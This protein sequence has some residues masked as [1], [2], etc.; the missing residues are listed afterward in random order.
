M[1]FILVF[2]LIF[3]LTQNG[4]S[5]ADCNEIRIIGDHVHKTKII[6]ENRKKEY[7]L[8]SRETGKLYLHW[9]TDMQT[10]YMISLK[11]NGKKVQTIHKNSIKKEASCYIREK[12]NATDIFTL[13]ISGKERGELEL[14]GRFYSNEQERRIS[15]NNLRLG[16][17]TY[18][19][20][21]YYRFEA[22]RTGIL[23]LTTE[24]QNNQYSGMVAAVSLYDEKKHRYTIGQESLREEMGNVQNYFVKKGKTYYIGVR[25][26]NPYSIKY[27]IR[28]IE[29]TLINKNHVYTLMGKNSPIYIK[30]PKVRYSGYYRFYGNRNLNISI[31][32]EN[33]KELTYQK[34]LSS[35]IVWPMQTG[36]EYY[37]RVVGLGREQVKGNYIRYYNG[38]NTKK[39]R[40]VILKRKKK[41]SGYFSVS[42]LSGKSNWFY[43]KKSKKKRQAVL[44]LWLNG[45]IRIVTYSNSG[46]K[47]DQKNY[48]A[49]SKKINI[50]IP[51][52]GLYIQIEKR[53][54]KSS[55]LYMIF[56]K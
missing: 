45:Q 50:K 19:S 7:Q 42:D 25:D 8:L 21:Q 44:K 54:S 18:G 53:N 4:A 13:E 49:I 34:R 38:K 1:V 55:G 35:S 9:K 43:V 22:E 56:L 27:S 14:E 17:A 41:F 51:K 26:P 20:T 5:R 31:C 36:K 3:F 32:N 24:M 37:V 16:V 2:C 46:K 6:V 15:E 39:K 47:I 33:F 29:S 30:I 48:S 23:S 52:K 11:K 10:E 40:S 12:I 28:G